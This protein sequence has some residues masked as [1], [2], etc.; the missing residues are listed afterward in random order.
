MVLDGLAHHVL[1]YLNCLLK[2]KNGCIPLTQ[3]GPEMKYLLQEGMSKKGT[4]LAKTSGPAHL[5]TSLACRTLYY[6]TNCH[7]LH[8]GYCGHVLQDRNQ[9]KSL[10]S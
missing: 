5:D 4:L 1:A 9:V 10:L 3:G 2:V 8:V 6:M 7:E